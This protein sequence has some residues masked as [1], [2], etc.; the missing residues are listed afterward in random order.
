MTAHGSGPPT[1]GAGVLG[2]HGDGRPST[3]VAGPMLQAAGGSGYQTPSGH[4]PG[5]NGDI[6]IRTSAGL[7]YHPRLVIIAAW[8]SATVVRKCL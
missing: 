7:R 3:T 4:H 6:R 2:T 1:V 8:A 5:Y